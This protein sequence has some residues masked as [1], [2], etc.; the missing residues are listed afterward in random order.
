MGK[1]V[2]KDFQKMHDTLYED[3]RLSSLDDRS[4]KR[5]KATDKEG[6]VL[7]V[8]FEKSASQKALRK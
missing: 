1:N 2:Q 3:S 4:A 7:S 5:E 6:K 8:C